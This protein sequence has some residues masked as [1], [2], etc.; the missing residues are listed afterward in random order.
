M[1]ILG[2]FNLGFIIAKLA[3][4]LFII[5]QHAS[6]E[7]F[8]YEHFTR[9]LLISTQP[10]IRPIVMQLTAQLELVAID[11]KD[12][13]RKN[14]FEITSDENDPP[15]S[16]IKLVGI[17]QSSTLTFGMAD[18]EDLLH[19]LAQGCDENVRCTR[20]LKML[21]SKACR[22]SVMIGD[23]LDTGSMKRIVANMSEMTQPWNCP[24]GRPTMRHLVDLR[25][26]PKLIS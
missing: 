16:R 21:A 5:D 8:N 13:L 9:T 19:K 12:I 10:L 18:M 11:Y 7:K 2:Q 22:K 3:D 1:K 23:P 25:R 4:D 15:G 17:P 6:D 14:G 24:H 20:I 26:I